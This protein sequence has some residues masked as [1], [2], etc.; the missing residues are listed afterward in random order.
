MTAEKIAE[1]KR[2]WA[3]TTQGEWSSRMGYNGACLSLFLHRGPDSN[4]DRLC[5]DGNDVEAIAALHNAFPALIAALEAAEA[6]RDTTRKENDFMRLR[7]AE[8]DKACVYCELPKTEMVQCASG[9]PGCARADDLFEC[10]ELT[11][12][13]ER[14]KSIGAAEW[15]EQHRHDDWLAVDQRERFDKEAAELR[16]KGGA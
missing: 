11:R 7:L 4:G 9:F 3:A 5:G 15:L 8:S 16:R 1:L 13:D 14:N 2:L 6:E 10:D 12:R